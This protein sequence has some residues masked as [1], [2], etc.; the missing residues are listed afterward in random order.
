MQNNKI[1]ELT[2]L[3]VALALATILSFLKLYEMPQGGSLTLEMLPIIFISL[4]WGWKKGFF[5]GATY[6]VLQLL[7]G[8]KIYYP[9][10]AFID[11]PLA[12]GLL[13]FSGLVSKLFD[14]ANFKIKSILIVMATLLGGSF[15]FLAHVISGVVFFGKYA[16]EGVDVWVYSLGYNATYM[17][18][19][20]IITIVAMIL[21]DKGLANTSLNEVNNRE[22][23]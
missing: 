19:Q 4:R 15:R 9:S 18:P 3:G 12:F 10:Q 8:A 11:Y 5:L 1:Q 22:A 23:K 6:G 21:L 13:G 14:E 16:P 17:I 20:I 7:L 2:E